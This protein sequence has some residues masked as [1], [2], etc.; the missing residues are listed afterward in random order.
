[1]QRHTLAIHVEQHPDGKHIKAT[2]GSAQV[3]AYDDRA[4]CRNIE[5]PYERAYA[6]SI[7]ALAYAALHYERGCSRCESAVLT[8]GRGLRPPPPPR[9]PP[10][11]GLTAHEPADT[12]LVIGRRYSSKATCLVRPHGFYALCIMSRTI[13]DCHIIHHV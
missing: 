10:R 11:V 5:T 1:M 3:R 9:R 8:R 12:N 7:Y 2:I 4:W 6:L 13:T